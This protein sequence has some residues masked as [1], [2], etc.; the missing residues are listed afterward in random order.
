MEGLDG[1]TAGNSRTTN[2]TLASVL[3][4]GPEVEMQT[5]GG[6][7]GGTTKLAEDLHQEQ[8]LRA[9]AEA[10]SED[11]GR[12]IAV[13][14]SF[15]SHPRVCIS[16]P[17]SPAALQL[18]SRVDTPDPHALRGCSTALHVVARRVSRCRQTP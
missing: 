1:F 12:R 18:A 5:E 2:G 9:Q 15:P 3:D 11:K 14:A 10:E 4:E 16:S 6:G 13:R 17:S 8:E 7:G